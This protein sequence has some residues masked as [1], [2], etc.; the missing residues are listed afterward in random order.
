M[1]LTSTFSPLNMAYSI[2]YSVLVFYNINR[3]NNDVA[4]SY[5]SGAS[6]GTSLFGS[7]TTE[8]YIKQKQ[9]YINYLK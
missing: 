6:T 8:T 1:G 4:L 2:S 9:L 7:A 3:I 5:A